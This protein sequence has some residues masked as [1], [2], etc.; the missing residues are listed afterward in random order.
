MTPLKYHRKFIAKKGFTET[1]KGIGIDRST[2]SR[3]ENDQYEVQKAMA[4]RICAFFASD[5][6]LPAHIMWPK[7]FTKSGKLRASASAP[8]PLIKNI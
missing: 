7:C 4:E 8:F 1:W 5:L 2:L 6:L 3:I